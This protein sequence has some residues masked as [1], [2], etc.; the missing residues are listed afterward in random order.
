MK[1]YL[2]LF[3]IYSNLFANTLE[4][5]LGE[6]LFFDPILSKNKTQSCSTCHNP[7]FGFIDNRKNRTNFGGAVSVGDDG[8]SIGDRNTPTAGYASFSPDFNFKN[9][10][11]IGGQFLD[12]R[13]KDLSGQAGGPPLNPV[14]MGMDNKTEI[15]KRL[16]NNEFYNK[17]FMEIY[18]NDIFS[19]D[20][21]FY[22]KMTNSIAAFEKTNFFQPFDSKYDRYL[23][24]E[25]DLTPLEDLGKSL[26]FSNN[27]TNCSTCHKLQQFSEAKRETFSNYEYH[28]IG[29]PA[30][31]NLNIIADLG[32][33]NHTKNKTDKGKFKVPT[34]RNVAITAPYMH[35]GVFRNLRTVIRFYDKFLTKRSGMNP[36]T[37]RPWEDP[38]VDGN[39]SIDKLSKGRP[40]NKRKTKALIAFLRTLTDKRYEHLLINKNNRTR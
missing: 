7:N 2:L 18:G 21:K 1:K 25:Y 33:F 17:S 35:N 23:R 5:K 6:R 19:S 28:N 16:K 20:K 31:K 3:I 10:V 14:E 39:I 8:K 34:L 30:N 29:V 13:E 36:E 40:I 22:K 27:N 38:E 24:D 11:A 12:G 4:E 26:F 15:V 37:R 32:L 9:G